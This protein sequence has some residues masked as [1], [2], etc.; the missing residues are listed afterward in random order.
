[1][2]GPDVL[3]V[4]QLLPFEVVVEVTGLVGQREVDAKRVFEHLETGAAGADAEPTELHTVLKVAHV[5]AAGGILSKPDLVGLHLAAEDKRR[6]LGV[7]LLFLGVCVDEFA[8]AFLDGREPVGLRGCFFSGRSGSLGSL[9]FVDLLLQPLQFR[10]NICGKLSRRR[11]LGY[12]CRSLFR[13]A[14]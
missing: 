13:L 1:M 11:Q 4:G 3:Q 8:Q 10:R 7:F 5:G 12:R 2:T 9:Q 14:D 6:L